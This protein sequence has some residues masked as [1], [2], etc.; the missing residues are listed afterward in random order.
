MSVRVTRRTEGAHGVPSR[1]CG[2]GDGGTW[3]L[4][5]VTLP[6][7]GELSVL[8]SIGVRAPTPGAQVDAVRMN[9]GRRGRTGEGAA[10]SVDAKALCVPTAGVT[11]KGNAS[12]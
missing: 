6:G 10:C 9:A 7:V 1:S 12:L 5:L 2:S 3:T 4:S 8:P 11:G